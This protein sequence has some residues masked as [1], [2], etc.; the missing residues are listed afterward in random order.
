MKSRIEMVKGLVFVV[1]LLVTQSGVAAKGDEFVGHVIAVKRT[2]TLNLAKLL[3]SCVIVEDAKVSPARTTNIKCEVKDKS[4][5]P[6]DVYPSTAAL[7]VQKQI[8]NQ[9]VFSGGISIFAGGGIGYVAQGT[10]SGPYSLD[11]MK[12]ALTALFEERDLEGKKFEFY[13][14]VLNDKAG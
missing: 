1:C 14:H 4:S 6:T 10:F 3:Q 11:Q 8:A 12:T 5:A 2:T 7:V 9:F 13:A